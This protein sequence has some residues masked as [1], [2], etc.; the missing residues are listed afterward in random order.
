MYQIIKKIVRPNES[1]D[2]PFLP[3]VMDPIHIGHFT[4]N[5]NVTGKRIFHRAEPGENS[6]ERMII[7]LWDSKESWDEFNAD[8]VMQEMRDKTS[9]LF[10]ELGITE[11]TVS[12]T[13]F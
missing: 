4:A 6:L 5:Y 3:T 2:F 12:S 10:A 8:P 9:Q 13:E 7:M 1:V 11:E